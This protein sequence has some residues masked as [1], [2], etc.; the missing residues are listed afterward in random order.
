LV[1]ALAKGKRD[2]KT[3]GARLKELRVKAGL[4]QAELGERM[5][6]LPTNIARLE[7]GGRDPSWD[8]VKRLA[9]ALGVSTDDFVTET[10]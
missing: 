2:A 7:S 8:T 6:M 9:K 3:F 1:T 10:E 4:T 5:D